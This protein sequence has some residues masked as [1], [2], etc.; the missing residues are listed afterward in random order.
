VPRVLSQAWHS[1][2]SARAVAL[3]AILALAIG[4]GSTTAIYT[5]VNSVMLAPLPYANGDRF[6]ALYGATFSEP[7]QYSAH[8]WPDL[9]EYQR[10]TTSFDVRCILDG[11][12]SA[13]PLPLSPRRRCWRRRSLR[14]ARRACRRWSRFVTSPARTD[15]RERPPHRSRGR[16]PFV[17][18]KVNRR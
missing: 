1:W 12:R 9:L 7:G 13:S 6:V 3:F 14:G 11:C 4:I 18:M 17:V 15:D 10:R 16:M 2:R 8:A 5:V